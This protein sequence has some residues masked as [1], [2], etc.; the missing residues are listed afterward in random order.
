MDRF[1]LIAS[2]DI[3][4]A[5]EKLRSRTAEE[6]IQINAVSVSARELSEQE[7]QVL[8]Q[9]AELY[10]VLQQWYRPIVDHWPVPV[11]AQAKKWFEALVVARKAARDAWGGQ[12]R[13]GE[14]EAPCP[15]S[16]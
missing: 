8:E 12:W 16:Q 14:V 15:L 3:R 9:Y 5:M 2:R 6:I 1:F 13:R 10:R 7:K 4:V 11:P